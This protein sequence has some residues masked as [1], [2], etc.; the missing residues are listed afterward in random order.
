[1]NNGNAH[2]NIA[3]VWLYTMS[4]LEDEFIIQIDPK[5]VKCVGSIDFQRRNNKFLLQVFNF[6]AWGKYVYSSQFLTFW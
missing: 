1:M 2:I 6:I 3:I 5:Q 4:T